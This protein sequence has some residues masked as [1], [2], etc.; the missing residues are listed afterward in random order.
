MLKP[1]DF[2]LSE[3]SGNEGEAADLVATCQTPPMFADRRLVIVRD[4]KFAAESRRLIADYLRDPLLS[5]TLC[6]VS[7]EKKPDAKDALA[8]AVRALDGIALFKALRQ[9]EAVAKLC[10]AARQAG[11][12]LPT[13]AAEFMVE[14][15]GCEWGI[16]RAEL[17]KLRLFLKDRKKITLSDAAACLGYHQQAS[18]FE[19][20]RKLEKRDAAGSLALLRRMLEEGEDPFKLLYDVSRAVNRQLR[21][22]RLLKSGQPPDR[23]FQLLR[24]NAY[25]DREYLATVGR[26]RETSLIRALR[27]CVET[28]VALKSKTW[29]EPAIELEQLVLRVCGKA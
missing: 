7:S 2:N 26:I 14:E 22:K 1:D 4:A 27:S 17:S 9:G 23:I 28:E 10:E 8:A 11:F 19:L 5:T 25:Y 29:L 21:A 6:L 18:P 12:E 20:P 13:E 16:L 24:L 3:Y 15:A